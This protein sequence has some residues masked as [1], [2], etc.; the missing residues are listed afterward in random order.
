MIRRNLNWQL[1]LCSKHVLIAVGFARPIFNGR[2][3]ILDFGFWIAERALT[4]G[5]S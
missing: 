3:P 5:S 2:Q 1:I 4:R